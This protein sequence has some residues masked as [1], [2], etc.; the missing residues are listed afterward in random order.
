M[1]RALLLASLGDRAPA[2]VLSATDLDAWFDAAL[3]AARIAWP[4]VTLTD[5]AYAAHIASKIVAIG[6]S[7]SFR[8]LHTTELYLTRA[9]ALGDPR[10]I[11]ALR[12]RYFPE[13]KRALTR[14]RIG[15]AAIDDAL[16]SLGELLFVA[17]D[18]EAPLVDDYTGV[19]DVGAWARAVAVHAALRVE[20]KE[21]RYVAFDGSDDML[22]GGADFAYLRSLYGEEA[23]RALGI[24]LTRLTVRERNL[25]RQHHLDGVGIEAL[26]TQQKVHRVTIFRWMTAA[27]ERLAR[28]VR[29]E[30]ATR[31]ELGGPTLDSVL[32]LA[33]SGL[34][35]AL[36]ALRAPQQP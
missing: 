2:D 20:R 26:A 29:S 5:E 30:L 6:P 12:R 7:R 10:A 36:A 23:K 21:Q 35:E 27:R 28:E 31:L 22:V 16:A 18:G 13:V 34:D 17:P 33:E 24:A 32:R 3:R 9:C 11:A 1:T 25:L 19:G 14:L 4:D 15:D 8:D